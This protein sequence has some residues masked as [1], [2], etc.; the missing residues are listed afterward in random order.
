VNLELELPGALVLAA[1]QAYAAPPRSY[2]TWQH[3]EEVV[4]R[5]HEVAAGPGWNQPREVLL[6]VVFHD[7]VYIAGR[8]DNE[9]R[10]AELATKLAAEHWPGG[11]VE[12]GRVGELIRWTA[13]HGS[14]GVDDVDPQ[15]ALFLDCDM[16]ILGALPDDFDR[17]DRQIRDE[18]AAIPGDA[19]EVGRRRFLQGLLDRPRIFLSDYFHARLDDG[20]RA[21]LYRR[22][23]VP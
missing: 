6:A 23:G 8:A 15:A 19:Y 13:R 12:L 17:Y 16:A 11:T 2:H 9:A 20:A 3:V 14:L 1:Q 18:Y 10:S 7:A 4:R 22:L 5:Y 21:N